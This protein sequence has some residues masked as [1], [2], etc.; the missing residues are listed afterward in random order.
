MYRARDY[1]GRVRGGDP[2]TQMIAV[3]AFILLLV[4]ALPYLPVQVA[5]NGVAC[6]NLPMPKNSGSNQSLLASQIDPSVLRLE[7]KP[8]AV[9]IN[10]GSPLAL[11][12][13]RCARLTW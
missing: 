7:L 4:V 1:W 12:A 2:L 13:K 10:Q 11:A 5:T 8:D 3:A 6:L 9:I